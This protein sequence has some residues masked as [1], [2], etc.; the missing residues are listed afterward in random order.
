MVESK[1]NIK[2][3]NI[4][5]KIFGEEKTS[6]PASRQVLILHGWGSKSERWQTVAKLL[7]GRGFKVIIPDL[8]GFGKSDKPNKA[9][10]LDDYSNIINELVSKL[11]LNRFS[12]LGHSFGGNVAIK[13]S[14]NNP[15]KIER[16]YLVGASCIRKESFR[17][18][19]LYI[20]SKLFK[21]LSFIPPIKKAFYRAIKSDYAEIDGIMK[22][23]YLKTIKKDLSDL[24]EKINVPTLVI[25]GERDNITSLKN[26]YIINSKIRNSEIKIIPRV[27]HN[28]HLE[29]PGL[30][31]DAI[32]K[33]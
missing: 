32:S 13:Y 4:Y 6:L 22:E 16:M 8:P 21:F 25:W 29:C 20:L 3:L 12:L 30:L 17:K 14:L 23:I 11:E 5:Y 7:S 33:E 15:E 24:L 28:L 26:A 9:W 2:G 18:K 27:K 1:I 31:A 10:G 19:V